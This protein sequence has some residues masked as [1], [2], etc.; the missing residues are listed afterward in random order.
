MVLN[1]SFCDD[2]TRARDLSGG[3]Q[4]HAAEAAK[5][6]DEKREGDFY[7]PLYSLAAA[8]FDAAA[9]SAVE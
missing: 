7:L 1:S 3:K 6:E 9:N 5:G 8:P 4:R 2:Q